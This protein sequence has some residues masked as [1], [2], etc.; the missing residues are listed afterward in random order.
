MLFTVPAENQTSAPSRDQEVRPRRAWYALCLALF[1][2]ATTGMVAVVCSAIT[3]FP[4]GTQ[5]LVP[6]S[7]SV[8][9]TEPGAYVLWDELKTMYQG[10]SYANSEELPG[11][12]EIKVRDTASGRVLPFGP[13][14]GGRETIGQV[15]RK[16][17]GEIS[18]DRPGEYR[19][20]VAGSF[21]ER[22]F[23]LRRSLISPVLRA[24]AMIVPLGLLGWVLAPVA[25]LIVFIKRSSAGKPPVQ[26]A[27]GSDSGEGRGLSRPMTAKEERTY[28]LFCHLG[29]LSGFVVPFGNIIVPLILWITKK[30]E[31][32]FIDAHGKEALNFQISMLIYSFVCL[33]L[34]LVIIGIFLLA[35][36]WLFNLVIVIIAAIRASD[37]EQYRYPLSIRFVR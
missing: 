4:S 3:S 21:P 17:I 22:I 36:L 29:A 19:I 32:P 31:S 28:A 15:E 26:R 33:L 37:G 23:Y 6:G 16:T 24:I 18:I 2:A 12:M 14:L 20:D 9:V 35:A 7:L 34:V 1:L 10:K 11:G 5:F 30:G 8:H 27:A 13:S 25:G